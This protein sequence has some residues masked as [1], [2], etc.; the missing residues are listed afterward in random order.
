MG[1]HSPAGVSLD[2]MASRAGITASGIGPGIVRALRALGYTPA[3]VGAWTSRRDVAEMVESSAPSPP[4]AAPRRPRTDARNRPPR[5]G[6]R[7]EHHDGDGDAVTAWRLVG[8][9]GDRTVWQA[10]GAVGLLA[11]AVSVAQWIRAAQRAKAGGAR[12]VP[13]MSAA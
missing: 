2:T 8:G 4:P 10:V 3:R 11:V 7:A 12:R 9:E 5:T 1:W 6:V 13:L